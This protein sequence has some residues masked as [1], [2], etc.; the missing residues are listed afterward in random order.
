MTS[1]VHHFI[2]QVL[3]CVEQTV[4]ILLC[5]Q[6]ISYTNTDCIYSVYVL[7][8]EPIV[9]KFYLGS[10][11]NRPQHSIVNNTRVICRL[12]FVLSHYREFC[13]KD[14]VTICS[15]GRLFLLWYE[16]IIKSMPN[17]NPSSFYRRPLQGYNM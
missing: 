6:H 11:K 8:L 5:T 9:H 4:K 3:F 7:L 15:I 13:Y 17:N 1:P 16:I 2:L 14:G 12:R 10:N